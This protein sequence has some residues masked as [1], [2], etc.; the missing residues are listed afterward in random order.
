MLILDQ[1]RQ[2]ALDGSPAIRKVGLWIAA[3]PLRAISLS[4]DEIALQAQASQSAVNRFATHAGFT[5]FIELRAALAAQ[6]Q[7]AQEPIDKLS[8]LDRIQQEHPFAA[9]QSGLLEAARNLDLQVLQQCAQR[10]LEARQVYTLGLG[11]SHY[12][13][14]FAVSALMPYVQGATHLSEGGGTEQI[15]RRMSRLGA[16]DVLL[17]ISVPRYSMEAVNLSRYARERGVFVVALTDQAASPLAG[18]ADTVLLAPAQHEVLSHSYVSMFALIEA[19]LA[20]LVR[21]HPQAAAITTD[22]YDTML[23]HLQMRP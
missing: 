10:L 16:G 17:T 8:A 11:M 4:A 20:C 13:A 5:G 6:L 15:L 12:A 21:L 9:A 3:H 19:L 2:S 7:D 18:V 14:G 22:L 23:P 1:L